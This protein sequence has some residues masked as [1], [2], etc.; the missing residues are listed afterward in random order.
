MNWNVYYY[1]CNA[2]RIE[3]FNIFDHGG[4]K[5]YVKLALKRCRYKVEFDVELKRELRYYFWSK[6]EWEVIIT[7][8]VGGDREKDATKID[9]FQQVMLNWGAFVNYV[10]DNKEEL[11]EYE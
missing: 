9:V 1:N 7:S 3:T 8:W 11:L 4:F 5:L 6:A 10:W 2:K